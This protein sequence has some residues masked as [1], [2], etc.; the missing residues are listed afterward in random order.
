MSDPIKAYGW[1]ALPRDPKLFLSEGCLS[2]GPLPVLVES[3]RL[4]DT[5]LAN[6]ILAYAKEE[7]NS[8][9]FNHSMRV[10]YY[11]D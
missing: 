8:G 1:T 6:S 10:F 7:L 2:T 3:V 9:T 4:P 5:P 11:G